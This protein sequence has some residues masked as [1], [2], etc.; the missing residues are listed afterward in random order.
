LLC[1][2]VKGAPCC[3]S[4]SPRDLSS[5]LPL[6]ISLCDLPT[7]HGSSNTQFSWSSA[8]S[9]ACAILIM[10]AANPRLEMDAYIGGHEYLLAWICSC[11]VLL[12]SVCGHGDVSQNT[13]VH[14]RSA[15][16]EH[17]SDKVSSLPC[18]ECFPC[19]LYIYRPMPI[20]DRRVHIYPTFNNRRFKR[21]VF[22][23]SSWAL[24]TTPTSS[25][26]RLFPPN[27]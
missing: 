24:G 18:P 22:Y 23:V 6:C 20:L 11:L 5:H 8:P 10:R 25:A 12:L 26:L 1:Y 7:R 3:C 16:L 4:G 27:H 15:P 21:Q 9:L 14:C 2:Q 13:M 19:Q 17:D